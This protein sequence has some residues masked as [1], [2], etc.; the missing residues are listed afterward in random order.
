MD[1]LSLESATMAGDFKVLVIVDD[2][3]RYAEAFVTPNEKGDTA[4]NI[5]VENVICR[6]GVPEEIITDQG[7]AFISDLFETLCYQLAVDKVFTTAYHPQGNGI[8]ERMHSTLYTILRSLTGKTAST[9]RK[10][11]PYALY[12][13][14]TTVHK[15]IG[16]SP[17]KA[18]YGYSPRHIA[19]EGLPLEGYC[20]VDE[21][22]KALME[23]HNECKK[24][25]QEQQEKRNMDV[26]EKR[27]DIDYEP[28]DLVKLRIHER[29]SK[30]S[31]FWKGPYTVIRKISQV[32]Y[33]IDLPT[34]T[35]M[36][37]IIH[38]QHMKPWYSRDSDLSH[39]PREKPPI[40]RIKATKREIKED[41][42]ANRPITRAYKKI[43]DRVEREHN[44]TA[45][46]LPC[47]LDTK[48]GWPIKYFDSE[49]QQQ[50][51][52]NNLVYEEKMRNFEF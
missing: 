3:T 36:S 49:Q 10:Q 30:L 18:L 7:S 40:Q 44:D 27:K 23:I 41:N 14:R 31:P 26:N 19:L 29:T 46:T 28:G 32:N 33:E 50:R 5:L 52:I 25:L 20:P 4:A 38:V 6:Y 17:H 12:V 43:L 47:L 37:R 8:N 13:Y 22:V 15:A 39:I 45:N 42:M 9:W 21:R 16:M 1:F 24:H 51:K 48:T 35:S 34:D 11:L 2:L